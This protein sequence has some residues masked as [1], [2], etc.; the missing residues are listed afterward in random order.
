MLFWRILDQ[1]LIKLSNW[2][3][4][5]GIF[6]IVIVFWSLTATQCCW[7]ILLWA[8]ALT[9]C[10]LEK[11]VCG[12]CVLRVYEPT[13]PVDQRLENSPQRVHGTISLR[14]IEGPPYIILLLH[15]FLSKPDDH[16]TQ[17]TR[18]ARVSFTLSSPYRSWD[19]SQPQALLTS[20]WPSPQNEQAYAAHVRRCSAG[21]WQQCY[22]LN[23]YAPK[24]RC[25][26]IG[27]IWDVSLARPVIPMPC[28]EVLDKTAYTQRG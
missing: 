20:L 17:W 16:P 12:D 22:L 19:V 10:I 4:R 1:C 23:K 28:L 3:F 13:R 15:R 6:G 14:N 26:L 9:M 25:W 11:T 7:S 18:I 5:M 21:G 2:D 24:Q 27:K 8:T